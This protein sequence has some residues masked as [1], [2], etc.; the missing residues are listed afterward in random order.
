MNAPNEVLQALHAF[1]E[2]V[3]QQ[4]LS[5][6][7]IEDRAQMDS[8]EE[9]LRES[10]DGARPAPRR[11]ED[12]APINT[13]AHHD[14]SS[15]ASPS[16]DRPPLKA[17]TP[18]RPAASPSPGRKR[19][20]WA[21]ELA[22]APND[23]KKL[24]AVHTRDIPP[25]FYTP[26]ALP[27]FLADY[28]SADLVPATLD[29]TEGV[30]SVVDPEGAV[31]EVDRQVRTFFGIASSIAHEPKPSR[32]EPKPSHNEPKPSRN[33]PKPSRTPPDRSIPEISDLIV[34]SASERDQAPPLQAS[35][36]LARPSSPDRAPASQGI[37]GTAVIVHLLTGGT[38]HGSIE[39]F[40]P[41]AASLD[42]LD[43][44]SGQ[45]TQIPTRDILAIFFGVA[46]GR[47]STE[48]AGHRLVIKLV[49]GRQVSG[50]SPDYAPG[51]TALTLIPEPR[52]GNL[53]R[54][55]VPAWAV[56]GIDYA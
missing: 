2:L 1:A 45:H 50:H 9:M 36:P 37:E 47:P 53:D 8:L 49:N 27:S 11:I 52:R 32:N 46:R 41:T 39:V 54:I 7:G 55:W 5:G 30:T 23:S 20:P 16:T 10:I 18:N 51:A 24:N 12:P 17:P 21:E 35:A 13:S 22:I 34:P 3:R 42:L 4:R 25:S 56:R 19:A 6:L 28:Y 48:T 33:E 29:G 38:I 26:S 15:I 40:D 31:L 43:R 44:K 14:T